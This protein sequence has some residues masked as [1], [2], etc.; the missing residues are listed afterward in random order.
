MLASVSL[1]FLLPRGTKAGPPPLRVTFLA[2]DH[3]SAALVQAPGG[4]VGLV[5]AGAAED[6][7]A[8]V[9]ML[10]RRG[11]RKLDVVVATTWSERY[12]GGLPGLLKHLPVGRVVRNQLYVRTPVGERAFSEMARRGVKDF[13][14][15]PGDAETLFYTP[16]CQMES[17]APTGPM[18]KQFEKDPLCSAVYEFQYGRTSVLCLGEASRTH[19]QVMWR[20]VTERPW[21]QVLQIGRDGGA[22]ALFPGMLKDLRTRYAVL[23]IPGKSHAKPAN[24]TLDALRKAGVKVYR[25]DRDGP[26]TVTSDS[27][28][29]KVSAGS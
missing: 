10:R 5:G 29:I 15:P 12:L 27:E 28:H 3:G 4:M 2:L 1:C 7:D 13:A 17:V 20:E 16:P 14:P 23:T 11:V 26:I 21:G 6:A 22:E 9:R 18:L 8:M 25:T 19:Q 24:V